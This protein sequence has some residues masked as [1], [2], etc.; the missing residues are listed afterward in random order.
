MTVDP[1]PTPNDPYTPPPRHKDSSGKM[2]RVLI[3]G[4]II[5]AGG[6]GYA[7]ISDRIEQA[8]NTPLVQEDQEFAE[9][10]GLAPE[11]TLAPPISETPLAEPAEATPDAYALPPTATEPAPTLEESPG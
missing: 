1:H 8:R 5:A 11:D 2:L 7:A 3:L 6:L 10:R 9:M 4:G